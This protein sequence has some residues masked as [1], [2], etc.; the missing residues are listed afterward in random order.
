MSKYQKTDLS[1]EI[2]LMSKYQNADNNELQELLIIQE[3]L[4]KR[5]KELHHE[6]LGGFLR[7]QNSLIANA[8]SIL[9]AKNT[10]T[11]DQ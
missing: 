6:N 7:I 10:V 3:K 1:L 4:L 5:N 2:M 8:V 9:L 11:D